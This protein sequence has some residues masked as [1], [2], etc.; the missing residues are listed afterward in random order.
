MGTVFT[1]AVIKSAKRYNGHI[2]NIIGD[3]VMIVFE[4]DNVSLIQQIS[5]PLPLTQYCKNYYV[6]VDFKCGIMDFGEMRLKVGIRK[7]GIDGIEHRGLFGQVNQFL[8][9]D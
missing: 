1:N 8:H 3:R 7:Y 5:A 4:P 2:R 9:Q 6:P